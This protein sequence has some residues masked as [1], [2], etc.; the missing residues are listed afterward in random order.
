MESGAAMEAMKVA[1]SSGDLYEVDRLYSE[2]CADIGNR[3][4]DKAGLCLYCVYAHLNFKDYSGGER[5]LLEALGYSNDPSCR[6]IRGRVL[7]NLFRLKFNQGDD[8]TATHYGQMAIIELENGLP[9]TRN[10]IEYIRAR[11]G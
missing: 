2:A 7:F 10:E 5:Y 11:M 6:G 4:E 1:V 8:V 3:I 9:D